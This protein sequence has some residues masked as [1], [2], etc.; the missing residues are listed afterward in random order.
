MSFTETAASFV[1]GQGV[2]KVGSS[3]NPANSFTV[4]FWF[5]QDATVPTGGTFRNYWTWGDDFYFNPYIYIGSDVDNNNVALEAFDG[6]TFFTTDSTIFPIL[7][8]WLFASLTYDSGTHVLALSLDGTLVGT[9]TVD[10]S[11]VTFTSQNELIGS[12]WKTKVASYRIWQRKL[13]ISDILEERNNY[14]AFVM[15]NLLADRPLSGNGPSTDHTLYLRDEAG[16]SP[17]Q[18]FTLN[19]GTTTSIFGP[20]NEVGGGVA[21]INSA[22]FSP[23]TWGCVFFG[24]SDASPIYL[25]YHS[26]QYGLTDGGEI[27]TSRYRVS[28][29]GILT[30][31]TFSNACGSPTANEKGFWY[32]QQTIASA[33]LEAPKTGVSL[34]G[35]GQSLPD[36]TNSWA[37]SA[38]PDTDGTSGPAFY[39][40]E[41]FTT[42]DNWVDPVSLLQFRRDRLYAITVGNRL[43]F[44]LFPYQLGRTIGTWTVNN[45][46]LHVHWNSI[47]V[48]SLAMPP[49]T[50]GGGGGTTTGTI[51][52][53]KVT[54]PASSTQSF[55][56]TAG[57]GLVP[58]TFSLMDGQSQFFVLV[59]P[60]TYSI[61]ETE[62]PDWMVS[63]VVSNGSPYTAITVSSSETVTVTVTNT[64]TGP[65]SGIYY[66]HPGK[67]NDTLYTLIAG[68]T[69]QTVVVKIPDPFGT[70]PYGN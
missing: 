16:V 44:S 38:Q 21:T 4:T 67:I 49:F 61:I 19:T 20:Y 40:D 36:G 2:Y 42:N 9:L 13:S 70:I 62:R 29:Y 60:G 63:Y 58:S 59:T 68:T 43:T 14:F 41:T 46:Y 65:F 37:T 35:S 25:K 33:L 52:V 22:G 10:L 8:R 51:I 27:P 31:V 11:A 5:N 12:S 69:I 23:Y 15:T 3:L 54:V 1:T 47:E 17:A 34:N 53:T 55:T 45:I 64:S 24:P 7:S 48:P 32:L 30:S 6:S 50:G 18:D 26:S 28:Y 39:P 57:G 56:F 66:I